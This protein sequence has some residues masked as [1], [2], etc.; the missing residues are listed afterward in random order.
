MGVGTFHAASFMK[1]MANSLAYSVLLFLFCEAIPFLLV[2]NVLL[3][4]AHGITTISVSTFLNILLQPVKAL[5]YAIFSVKVDEIRHAQPQIN[6]PEESSYTFINAFAHP[7][8]EHFSF[9]RASN[10][11]LAM[12]IITTF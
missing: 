9:N 8:V 2:V 6:I 10:G 7:Y 3:V 5:Q 11:T 12:E 4:I 1:N